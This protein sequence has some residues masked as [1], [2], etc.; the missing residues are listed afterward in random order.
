M[1]SYHVCIR[2]QTGFQPALGV[3]VS[4]EKTRFLRN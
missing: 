1:N 2:F 4:R 3:L